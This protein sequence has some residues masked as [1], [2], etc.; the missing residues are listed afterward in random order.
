MIGNNPR[1]SVVIPAYNVEQYIRGCI[2][3]VIH[4]NY[5]DIEIIVIDD[6]SKDRTPEIL[7]DLSK[8]DTRVKVIHKEN[9]GVSAARNTG[10][11]NARGDYVTFVDGDD[12]ICPDYIDYMLLLV[13]TSGSDFGLSLNCFKSTNEEQIDNDNIRTISPQEATALL[14][15]PRVI[16]GCWNKIYRLDFLKKNKIFFS[17]KLFY[18]EGLSFITTAAQ[19][20]NKVTIGERKVYKYRRD[21]S[22]SA[23]TNFRIDSLRNGELSL[24]LI[25]KNLK[26]RSDKVDQMLL[27]HSCLYAVG[28]KTQLISNKKVNDYRSDYNRWNAFLKDN[29]GSVLSFSSVEKY[30]KVML[31]AGLLCPRTLSFLMKKKRDIDKKATI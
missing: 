10:I 6:G 28:G 22:S 21:N 13:E 29:L 1:V 27:L 19:L 30:Y 20:A 14:L 26:V 24:E 18:G 5:S 12:K 8:K 2:D 3:S 4:Q 31:I 16:V 17:E 11:L 15:S 23:T 9:G 25:K 7:D